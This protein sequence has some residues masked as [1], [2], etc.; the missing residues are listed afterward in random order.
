MKREGGK[1]R[2]ERERE[3]ER[4]RGGER[5]REGEREMSGLYRE[6]PLEERKPSPWAGKFRAEG[7]ECASHAL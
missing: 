1:K 2:G 4:E 5:G 3:R 6:Q 7:A